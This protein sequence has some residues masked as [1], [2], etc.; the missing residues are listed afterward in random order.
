VERE[1]KQRN[2]SSKNDITVIVER[3]ERLRFA[4]YWACFDAEI[5]VQCIRRVGWSGKRE[6]TPKYLN[7]EQ[8]NSFRRIRRKIAFCEL[9][10]LF[11][12]RNRRA[13]RSARRMEWKE[14]K[15]TEISQA[16]TK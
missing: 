6:K 2:I 8:N 10:G 3:E 12:T 14:R 5:G 4:S 7:Q 16:R 11:R 1:K 13:L 15:N 9:Q